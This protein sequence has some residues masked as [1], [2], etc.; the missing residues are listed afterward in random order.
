MTKEYTLPPKVVAKYLRKHVKTIRL[1]CK[2]GMLPAEKEGKD[3][4]I[5][6]PGLKEQFPRF[7][8]NFWYEVALD[9]YHS[10]SD[11][12]EAKAEAVRVAEDMKDMSKSPS[13]S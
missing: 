2:L 13:G 6:V 12:L 4:E 1:H 7:G 11:A 5:S 10:K 3:W 8:A 9:Y